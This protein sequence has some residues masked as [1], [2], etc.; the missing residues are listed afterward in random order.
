MSSISLY[1]SKVQKHPC[2]NKAKRKQH[3]KIQ[4]IQVSRNKPN[5]FPSQTCNKKHPIPPNT[6]LAIFANKT[7][8][9]NKTEN[10]VKTSTLGAV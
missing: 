1:G 10:K 2:I 8:K 5:I 9:Q 6:P 7:R 4:H 3:M